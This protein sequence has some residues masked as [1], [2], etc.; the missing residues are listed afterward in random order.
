MTEPRDMYSRLFEP[1]LFPI[2]DRLNG[3]TI[4][5]K[6]RELLRSEH[7]DPEL[8][9]RRQARRI[10]QA[11]DR[12][13]AGSRF[14]SHFWSSVP[15]ERRLPSAHAPL[16]GLPILTKQDLAEAAGAFP[17]PAYRGRVITSRTS[18]S[19]G[20]PMVFYRSIEQ[21]SWFWALRFRM[22][23]WSGYHPGDPYLEI[24]L[25]P[26]TAWKKRLQDVLFRC[27]FLTFN[28][29]NQDSARIVDLLERHRIP[30]INGFS[31]SLYVL[32]RYML[33]HGRLNTAVT[34][35][36]ATGDTLFPVYRETIERAFNAR[37]IDYYGA[38]G[39]GFHVASQCPNSGA[40]YHLHPENAV[41]EIL[42]PDGPVAPGEAGRIVVTQFDNDAMPLIRYELGDVAVAARKGERCSCGRTLPLLQ[43]IEGRVPD[44]IATPTGGFLVPHFFVVL[45]KN[46]A[47]VKLYQ[48]V[49][50]QIDAARVCLVGQPGA[51][52]GEV[53]QA[54]RRA[55]AEA[56][57]STV[58]P[59][60]EWVDDIPLSG[61]GK[62]RLVIS[63]MS[64]QVLGAHTSSAAAGADA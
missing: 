49:Q 21:E 46:L 10:E 14:Y 58:T 20:R 18:G 55:F 44:L 54:V 39:E 26:R 31:S 1:T 33:D 37:V 19:T 17:E 51:N 5:A 43:A 41:L 56:T 61:S 64:K 52:R 12:V 50:D 40:R 15:R 38:G 60:F 48:I 57:R 27:S 59:T 36:T 7:M 6:Y 9:E 8:V 34:G 42:G 28:A 35:I 23:S 32:A 22:W 53:E 16:D 3:T 2:L 45:F 62:R 47:D 4:H 29:D 63:S 24:N 13:R 11:V 25:N 30:N